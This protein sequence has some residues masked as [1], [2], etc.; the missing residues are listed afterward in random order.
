MNDIS[1][2]GYVAIVG[3]PNV[4]KSTLLNCILGQKISITSSKPQTTRH[5]ILG[6]KTEQN[7]QAVYVDTPGLHKGVKHTLNRYMN[8]VA[9]Q[10]LDTVDVIGFVVDGLRWTEE[11]EW[12]L[13]KLKKTKQP[14]ILIVNK[15]DKIQPKTVLLSHLAALNEKHIFANIVPLSAKNGDNVAALEEIIY[16][17][18][19]A[20]P[21]YFP[22]D[23]VTDRSD[24]FLASE[25]IREKLMRSLQ[26]ELPY[27]LA[28]EIE[29]FKNKDNVLHINAIIWV[30]RDK[31]KAIVI[32]EGGKL[33]KHI[34]QK[35]RLDMEKAFEQK[36]FLKLWVK[37]KEQW[38][39]D[40]RVL[41]SLGYD[42]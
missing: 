23:Q 28:V 2:C 15:V 21:H 1:R 34:G 41:R 8:R 30:E 18:L 36:V 25:F 11:D 14:I 10:T 12:I 27:A 9:S 31:Q 22:E 26:Q 24:R 33:L 38:S 35:A 37:V 19:P 42:D 16:Q 7:K 17:L 13:A 32:G 40:E 3:R 6:I 29:E 20:S 5:R 39:T 4:G